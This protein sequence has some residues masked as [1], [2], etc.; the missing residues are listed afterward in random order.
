MS[1]FNTYLT[2]SYLGDLSATYTEFEFA[3]HTDLGWLEMENRT[4]LNVADLPSAIS[5]GPT[6]PGDDP[7]TVGVRA[8]G[9]GDILS[10]FFFSRKGA[11]QNC[12]LG[13]GPVITF[14]TATDDILGAR[15]WTIGPGTH[16]SA[17]LGKL[18]AGFF[19]WQSWKVGG[20]SASKPVNQ[21][22]GKPFLLYEL[23]EKWNLVYIPLSLSHSWN[24][25]SGEKWTVPVGGG[26]RRLFQCGDKKV[27][28][29]CQAF[30]YAARKPQ[31]PEWE[32]RFTI[33]CL[34]DD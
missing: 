25:K 34:L 26:V 28:L 15:Q 33:E 7:A 14:P 17:E 22:V 3:S 1:E 10:A 5:M 2:A 16:F 18:S 30:S 9:F 19:L 6:N 27:G 23:S 4:V 32:L 8:S 31:D 13:I 20:S 11:H 12:H 21:L 29:Q 24:A